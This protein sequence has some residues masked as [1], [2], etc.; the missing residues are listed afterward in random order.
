MDFLLQDAKEQLLEFLKQNPDEHVQ[1]ALE[2]IE[3][4]LENPDDNDV[5]ADEGV[6]EDVKDDMCENC[7][8]K[9]DYTLAYSQEKDDDRV[10]HTMSKTIV[11]IISSKPPAPPSGSKALPPPTNGRTPFRP[12]RQIVIVPP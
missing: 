2:H 10:N 1:Q 7:R 6:S 9:K 5:E 8:K 11:I 12:R 4:L 3:E